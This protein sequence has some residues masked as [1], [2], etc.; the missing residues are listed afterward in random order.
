MRSSYLKRGALRR[1]K[2]MSRSVLYFNFG[3]F[4][5]GSSYKI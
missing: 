5:K 4:C 1:K 2:M 3:G